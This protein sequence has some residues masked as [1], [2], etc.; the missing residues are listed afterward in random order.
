MNI[1]SPAHCS[2]WHLPLSCIQST[3]PSLAL[4]A[5][6]NYTAFLSLSSLKRIHHSFEA[7]FLLVSPTHLAQSSS[8]NHY[9]TMPQFPCSL[10]QIT[11]P[12]SPLFLSFPLQSNYQFWHS[13]NEHH[14]TKSPLS[15][16][17]LCST[18]AFPVPLANFPYSFHLLGNLK[19]HTSAK[20][21]ILISTKERLHLLDFWV[22]RRHMQS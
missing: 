3:L 19:Q 20:L 10:S 2:S 17:R 11:S 15:L 4:L 16:L 21:C 13:A 7:H 8:T 12:S 22:F 18:C 14:P 5:P 9:H 1:S 6:C